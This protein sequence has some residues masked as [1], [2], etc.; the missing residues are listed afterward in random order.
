MTEKEQM[1]I[2]FLA[3]RWLRPWPLLVRPSEGNC[4][5]IPEVDSFAGV[6][7]IMAAARESKINLF[8]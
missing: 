5:P 8:I 7:I 4:R 6:A 2:I 1:T 3:V